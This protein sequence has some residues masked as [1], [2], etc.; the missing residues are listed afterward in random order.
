MI[1]GKWMGDGEKG[2][3]GKP[4]HVEWSAGWGDNGRTIRFTALFLENGKLVPV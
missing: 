3:D 4:F 2:L 1:G